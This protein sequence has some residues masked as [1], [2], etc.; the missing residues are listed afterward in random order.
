MRIRGI[1]KTLRKLFRVRP[2]V[3]WCP[4]SPGMR[5]M[6][7]RSFIGRLFKSKHFATLGESIKHSNTKIG[8][9]HLKKDMEN[10]KQKHKP[11]R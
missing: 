4:E 9:L 8:A 11:C 1:R 3:L 7:Y 5:V 6:V 10:E 2:E